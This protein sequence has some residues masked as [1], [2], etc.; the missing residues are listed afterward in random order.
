MKPI[1]IFFLIIGIIFITIGYVRE[2]MGEK[3]K[4]IYRYIPRKALDEQYAPNMA[5]DVF[6]VMKNNKSDKWVTVP[7]KT[8]EDDS[9]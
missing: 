2:N 3:T 5:S 6:D 8:D 9:N 7:E 4:I 1:T